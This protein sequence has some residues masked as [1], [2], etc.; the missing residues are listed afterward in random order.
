MSLTGIGNAL[1]DFGGA[2]GSLFQ[3][4]GDE[5]AAQTYTQAGNLEGVAATYAGEGSTLVA[6]STAIQTAQTQRQVNLTLG[7]QQAEVSGAGLKGGGSNSYLLASSAQQGALATALVQEQ[8][9]VT[10]IGFQEQQEALLAQQQT[11]Y[12]LASQASSAATGSFIGGAL[13]G[14]AGI[15]ALFGL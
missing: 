7:S 6:Q 14:V 2:V 11:D 13:K 9:A 5:E 8:G 3:G 12:G 15:G 4:F 10:Q 1:G